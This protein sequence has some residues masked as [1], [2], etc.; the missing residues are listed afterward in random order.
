M[1]DRCLPRADWQRPITPS[2]KLLRE[3]LPYLWTRESTVKKRRHSF[4]TLELIY[5]KWIIHPVR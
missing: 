5:I 4:Y 1:S 3:M 2:A